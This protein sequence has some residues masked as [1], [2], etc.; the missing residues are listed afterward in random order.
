MKREIAGVLMILTLL[1]DTAGAAPPE[2]KLGDYVGTYLD[3]PGRIFEIVAG[4]ELFAV[5]DEAKY[6]LRPSGVDEFE[7]AGGEKIAF[8]RDP[9]GQGSG[10]SVQGEFHLRQSPWSGCNR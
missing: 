4:D 9:T 8:S 7:N 1:S 3:Q 5:Q 2:S 6:R 10:F